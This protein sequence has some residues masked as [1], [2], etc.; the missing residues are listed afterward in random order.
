MNSEVKKEQNIKLIERKKLEITGIKKIESLNSEEF[1]IDTSL[2][3]LHVR[4]D[5]LEMQQLD[6]ERGNLWIS[7]IISVVEYIELKDKSKKEKSSLF[8]KAFK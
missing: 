5:N 1:L 2:G 6:I 4:G 7:G 3:L 8:S